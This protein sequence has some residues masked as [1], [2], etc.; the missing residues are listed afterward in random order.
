[1]NLICKNLSEN[2]REMHFRKKKKKKKKLWEF[3]FKTWQANRPQNWWWELMTSNFGNSMPGNR[4][5]I[6][7]IIGVEYPSKMIATC[8]L[9]RELWPVNQI[10][11]WKLVIWYAEAPTP[12]PIPP[13]PPPPSFSTPELDANSQKRKAI[14]ILGKIGDV[15]F[16]A[17]IPPPHK[18]PT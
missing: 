3:K 9:I 18:F 5:G 17:K 15:N 1:M 8:W 7:P 2:F 6:F 4:S 13:S 12:P 14:E 10:N 16:P 11:Y